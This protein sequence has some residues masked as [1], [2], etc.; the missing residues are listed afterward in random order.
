MNIDGRKYMVECANSIDRNASFSESI[1]AWQTS[2]IIENRL[3]FD[4]LTIT[5][6]DTKSDSINSPEQ[7]QSISW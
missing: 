6:D 3:K 7:F 2:S 4:P 5:I 1:N